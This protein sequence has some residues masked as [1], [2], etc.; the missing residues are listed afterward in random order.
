MVNWIKHVTR[1]MSLTAISYAFNSYTRNLNSLFSFNFNNIIYFTSKG[2]IEGYKDSDEIKQLKIK[3]ADIAK[4][5]PEEIKRI[6][7]LSKHYSNELNSFILNAVASFPECSSSELAMIYRKFD[8][9]YSRFWVHYLFHFYLTDA[10]KEAGFDSLINENK[11]LLT[12]L[13]KT[14]PYLLVDQE[15]LK[16]LF[17]ELAKRNSIDSPELL[18]YMLPDEIINHLEG[19]LVINTAE[20]ENR[21]NGFLFFAKDGKK[22]YKS[23]DDAVKEK[24]K[25]IKEE[26]PLEDLIEIKGMTSYP[27]KV[28]DSVKIVVNKNDFS[29]IKDRNILVAHMTTVDYIS[30]LNKISAIVTDEGGLGCH[31]AILSREFKIPCIIGTEIATKVFR[32]DDIVEVNATK[33][34][35][36]IIKRK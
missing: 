25:E 31:A 15:F 20:L 26:K 35:V 18:Y 4:K 2:Q 12:E 7:H 16:K 14:N 36:K 21:K 19:D 17:F 5:N 8:K 6:L 33:G 10:L 13:R 1:E 29:K 27:G 28:V 30:Y 22:I 34:V 24:T 9:I 32:D 11:K 3:I 23:G